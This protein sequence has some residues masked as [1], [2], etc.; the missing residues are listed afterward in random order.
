MA[1]VRGDRD[2]AELEL[3]IN[4]EDSPAFRRAVVAYQT[5]R[6][7]YENAS[8]LPTIQPLVEVLEGYEEL[9]DSLADEKPEV[10]AAAL[11]RSL[12]ISFILGKQLE[13]LEEL[14][15]FE[16]EYPGMTARLTTLGNV[17]PGEVFGNGRIEV[18]RLVV[19]EL[20]DEEIVR[21]AFEARSL[22]GQVERLALDLRVTNPM[23]NV[24]T[25]Y[26]FDVPDSDWKQHEITLSEMFT[27]HGAAAI[28]YRVLPG[29]S[30]VRATFGTVPEWYQGQVHTRVAFENQFYQRFYVRRS[31]RQ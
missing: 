11:D 27:S 29:D 9:A 24:Q 3:L 13:T 5:I 30:I 4:R 7:M 21:L 10:A 16:A 19:G 14:K 20:Q 6:E 12:Q 22:S 23:R 1:P 28:D 2:Q 8:T 26:F 31:A 17:L 15:R 18:G 25:S